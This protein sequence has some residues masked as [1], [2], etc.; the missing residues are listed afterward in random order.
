MTMVRRRDER[1]SGSVLTL[2]MALILLLAGLVAALWAVIS[3]GHHRA[4]AA[5]DLA[6]LSAAG[7]LQGGAADP[8]AVA[9][10]IAAA[11]GAVV[12]RCTVDA[13]EVLVVAAVRLP[14]GKL[15]DPLVEVAARAGPV[16]PATSRSAPR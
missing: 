15:G 11:H 10:R 4:V 14:L 12:R 13:G 5:A 9:T 16:S 6:A 3:A 1:G 7:A 2:A 8:C